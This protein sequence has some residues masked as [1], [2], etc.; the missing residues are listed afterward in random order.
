MEPTPKEITLKID[1]QE[2]KAK[3]GT[4]ILEVAKS[5]GISI[6]TLCYL[7]AL[8]PF[9]SCRVCSVEIVDKRGRSRM[10]TSCNYPV[11][12]GLVVYTKSEKTI[13]IRK[14]LLDLLLARCP[15]VPK[16]QE[17]AAEYGIQKSSFYSED[18]NEDCILCGLC[19]R[20]CDEQVGV[21]AINFAKRGVARE[22]ATPYHEF[23]ND[24]I[25]CGACATVCPTKS[26]RTR[27]KTYPILEEDI[28][29][30]NG[31]FLKGTQDE[32]IGIY[33]Q[34]LAGKSNYNGQ[35][36]GMAT[37][38]LVSGM[39]KGIF[40]SAIVVQRKEGYQAEAV[41]AETTED[42]IKAK[43]TKY[44]RVKMMSLLEELVEKG[45]R[46]IALVGTP[47]EV[48]GARKIQ[49]ALLDK[50]P[51]LQLTIVGLFC[52]ESFDYDK[53]KA[54]TQRLMG[55]DLDSVDKTQI[56]KGKFIATVK[57]QDYA[58]A[59]KDLGAAQ[60]NGCDFCDDFTG[61]LADISVGS[62]GSPEGFSTVI[63]RS[64]VGAKLLENLQFIK[65]EANKD[66]ITKLSVLKK[67]R[68]KKHFAK[69]VQPEVQ[70]QPPAPTPKVR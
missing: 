1:N 7:K 54:E 34:I 26:K 39:Q 36:G 9:G 16:I 48:R 43:G 57:G 29:R 15:R 50:Y 40:D 52:F 32:N 38:L 28:K 69:I 55:I 70:V 2:V 58:V 18:E 22:V 3:E 23:S 42:I 6:P 59:V 11:E 12:E 44:L 45:K 53:L 31:Q 51:D 49:Q 21:H 37:A 27:A 30:I 66:E 20:V 35:D 24:C 19:T 41:V 56:K 64:E 10:V 68:A 63:V 61:S 4:P 47:C 17:M 33:Q 46:K 13:K 8:S 25:G 5:I 60:E 67:N 14:T 65:G 62:V